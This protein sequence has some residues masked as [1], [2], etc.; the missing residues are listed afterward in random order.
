MT[1]KEAIKA[2]KLINL[3]RVHPFYDWKEMKEVRERAIEALRFK[4][5][6]D[7]LYGIGLE[8][9]NWHQ[10]G[11]LISFDGFYE[12]AMQISEMIEND[13]ERSNRNIER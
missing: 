8:V 6:F 12:A 13:S 3:K 5:Y 7:E 2:L 11:D 10:N 4:P 9:A 1:E